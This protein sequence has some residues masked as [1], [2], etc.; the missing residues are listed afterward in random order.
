MTDRPKL[1]SNDPEPVIG[2]VIADTWRTYWRRQPRGYW[3]QVNGRGDPES[4]TKV[5]GNY[6]PVEVVDGFLAEPSQLELGEVIARLRRENPDRV[7]RVGFAA[8]HSYRG[9]Y[10]DLAFELRHNITIGEMLAAA[11]SAVGATFEGWKGGDYE[12]REH[13]DCWLVP[14]EGTSMGETLGA[15]LLELLLAPR[16]GA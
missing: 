10:Y 6:G 11:E 16:E 2:M 14:A 13:S 9:D 8:P 4:W 7:V 1:T 15:L 12:M 3:L 5:A